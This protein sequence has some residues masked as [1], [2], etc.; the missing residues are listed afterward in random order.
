MRVWLVVASGLV[1]ILAIGSTALAAPPWSEPQ[2]VG[3]AAPL[4]SRAT[5]AFAPNGTA[6]LS[7]RI[8]SEGQDRDS[9]ATVTPNGRLVDHAPLP[10]LLAADPAVLRRERVALLRQRVLSGPNAR[11][12]RVR[13]SLSVGTTAQ[14]LGKRR[15]RR[16]AAYTPVPSDD[17]Q[18]PR[19]GVAPNGDLAVVWMEYRGDEFAFGRYRVRLALRRAMGVSTERVP[20]PRGRSRATGSPTAWPSRSARATASSSRRR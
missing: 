10:D 13:L 4:V 3:A 18:G 19:L 16:L 7:R 14:P 5:L 12:R 1:A 15:P 11:V 17:I 9:L 6:L 8:S 20:W 2:S